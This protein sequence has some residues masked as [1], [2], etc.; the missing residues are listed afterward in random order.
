M[1]KPI[2]RRSFLKGM[3]VAPVAAKTGAIKALM[4]K[5]EQAAALTS[6]GVSIG[7]AQV[8]P[9]GTGILGNKAMYAAYKMGV[10]PDWAETEI[11]SHIRN[12]S[13]WRLSPDIASLRSVSLAAKVRIQENRATRRFW[14]SV[15]RHHAHSIA[16]ETFWQNDSGAPAG[17]R[18]P[19]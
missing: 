3:A 7:L 5:V 15:D 6:A 4:A 2:P 8:A 13:G 16:R 1:S 19:R 18:P 10:L 14:S 9:W 17:C 12:E 11:S